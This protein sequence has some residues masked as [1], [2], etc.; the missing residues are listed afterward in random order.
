V[1]ALAFGWIVVRHSGIYFAMLTLAFAQI[2]WAAASQSGATGGDNGVLGVWPDAWAQDPR[3]FYAV[4]LV[5]GA[6]GALALRR[7]LFSP[8]GFALR[9]C[10][11]AT[12]RAQAIGLDAPALRMAAS[13]LA[14][15]AAGLAG[16]LG[17]YFN[18]SVFPTTLSLGHSVDAL[19]MVLLGGI[20]TMAGPVVG[21]LVYTGLYD[22]LIRFTDLWRGALGL[23]IIALVLVFPQGVAG[24]ARRLGRDAAA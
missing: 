12:A 1:V 24:A 16:A 19:V 4:A 3:V 23:V 9:A 2:L 21:A 7:V 5:L 17:A 18:G 8:F 14:G 6:G 20:E 10:R 15:A 11:D 13:A 22:A